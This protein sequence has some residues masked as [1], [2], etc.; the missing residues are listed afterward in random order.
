MKTL[1]SKW[2]R[3]NGADDQEK[4]LSISQTPTL[5]AGLEVEST[6]EATER[7]AKEQL[8]VDDGTNHREKRKTERDKEA[9]KLT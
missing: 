5:Q 6:G 3:E 9:T 8:A 1:E 7:V 4:R 2:A